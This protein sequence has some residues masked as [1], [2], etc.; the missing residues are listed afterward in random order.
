MPSTFRVLST[1]A[2]ER[3]IKRLARKNPEI[4]KIFESLFPIL[5]VDPQNV[6]RRYNI[7]KLVNVTSGEGQ[8]R[9]RAGVYRLRYDVDGDAVTL[10]SINH[11]SEA[12]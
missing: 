2:F 11:R 5:E 4:P 6:S 10:H 3:S 9:I 8:W 7:K 12:Y 1:A